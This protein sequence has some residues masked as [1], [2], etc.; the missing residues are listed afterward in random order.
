M[1]P[2]AKILG[3]R[4]FLWGLILGIVGIC[5]YADARLHPFRL[6]RSEVDFEDQEWRIRC[7]ALDSRYNLFFPSHY[8]TVYLER[9]L[10]GRWEL[11]LAT[12]QSQ[13]QEIIPGRPTFTKT[14]DGFVYLTG[15]SKLTFTFPSTISLEPE[16]GLENFVYLGPPR[17]Y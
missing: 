15:E 3:K 7:D 14:A 16:Q 2:K 9:K 17:Q 10:Y 8:H 1:N 5:I 6:V 12:F 13:F 4:A 11:C